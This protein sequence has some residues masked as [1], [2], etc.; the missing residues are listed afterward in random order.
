MERKLTQLQAVFIVATKKT[1]REV[2]ETFNISPTLI[3]LIRKGEI[4]RRETDGVPLGT[5]DSSVEWSNLLTLESI[6]KLADPDRDV[7]LK[8]STNYNAW[9]RERGEARKRRVR[10]INRKLMANPN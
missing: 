4:Y 9:L 7:H 10:E 3:G 1:Y 8:S 6:A 2:S 5:M